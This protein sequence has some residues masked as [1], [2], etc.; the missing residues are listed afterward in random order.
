MFILARY[1]LAARCASRGCLLYTALFL[2]GDNK[3]DDA[4]DVA[5]WEGVPTPKAWLGD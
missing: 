1:R 2:K 4:G 3:R 5:F